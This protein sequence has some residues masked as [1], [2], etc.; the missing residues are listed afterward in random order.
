MNKKWNN[1][2]EKTFEK[3]FETNTQD[4]TLLESQQTFELNLENHSLENLSYIHSQPNQI[5][6]V[7]IFSQLS[8]FFE[9][10]FLFEKQKNNFA[11]I[12]GFAFGQNISLGEKNILLNLPEINLYSLFKTNASSILKKMNFSF[13]NKNKKMNAFVIK[14]STQHS[15]LVFTELAEPWLKLRLESLQKTL[16]KIS[17]E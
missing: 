16:M 14:V 10:G 8:S 7:K 13:I 9:L 3:I 6:I 1:S 4:L 11:A 15:I 5:D 12:Q 2:F 17:F